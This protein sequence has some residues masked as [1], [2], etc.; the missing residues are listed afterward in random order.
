M[1]TSRVSRHTWLAIGVSSVLLAACAAPAIKPEGSDTLRARLTRLQ[2]DSEL[3]SRA[4]LAWKDADLAVS[5]AEL[6]QSDRV[7]AAHLV[8]MADR[9]INIAEAQ[10]ENLLAVDERKAL[11][12]EREAMRLQARTR[13]ADAANDR[14]KVAERDAGDQKQQALGARADTLDA[15]RNSRELQQQID[16]LQAKVTERGLV[17]T[18]GDML[19]TSGT[20]EL[21]AV[22]STNLGKLAEFLNKHPER[23][24]AIEGHTDNIGNDTFNQALSQRRADAVQ[25]YLVTR[26][27]ISASR[28]TASGKGESSPIADNA[29]SKGR[30]QNRR[31]EVIIVELPAAGKDQRAGQKFRVEKQP[32]ESVTRG[33]R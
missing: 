28:L 15:E 3:A 26:E 1:N 13:E 2:S 5:A 19:F 24:A 18:L 29:T 21:G 7:V 16:E 11:S 25:S 22:E 30:Q 10:A 17:L 32:V 4:P 8:Y 9:K 31:V 14:A 23:T 33:D 20:A 27:S 6:P 12:E